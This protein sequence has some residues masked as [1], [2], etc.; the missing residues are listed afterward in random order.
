MGIADGDEKYFH[1]LAHAGRYY[2]AAL[3]KITFHLR[4]EFAIYFSFAEY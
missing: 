2:D 4:A 1:A 3:Y